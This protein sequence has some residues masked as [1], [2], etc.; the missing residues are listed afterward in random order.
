MRHLLRRGLLLAAGLFCLRQLQAAEPLLLVPTNSVWRFVKGTVEPSP[1]DL[2]AW[3]DNTFG[4]LGWSE[5]AAPFWYGESARFGGTGTEL[6]DMQNAYSTLY[7]RRRFTVSNPDVL[8]SLDLNAVCDDGFMAWINGHPVASRGAP[9][10]PPLF[11]S[12]ASESATEP[13]ASANY[14]IADFTNA[15]VTGDNVLAVQV[16]NVS[17][18]SSDLVFDAELTAMPRLAGP[19]TIASVDPPPG[20]VQS[21]DHITVTFT[22]PVQ[23][24][25]AEDFLVNGASASGVVGNGATYT[26]TFALPPYGEVQASWSTFNEI[27]D[28]ENPPRHFELAA[29]GSTW[30][31]EFVDPS[32]PNLA[33]IQ[34]PPGVAIPRL[35]QVELSFD[36]AVTGLDATDLTLNGVAATRLTGFGAGPYL[37]EFPEAVAGSADLEWVPGHGIASDAFEPHPFSGGGWQYTVEPGLQFPA[38][39]ITEFMAENLTAYRDEDQDP[40]DWIEIRNPTDAAV[41]LEGWSLSNAE[42][43]PGRWVFPAVSIPAR[44]R[45]V[46]FASAKDRRDPAAGARLHTNFKLNPTGGYLGLFSPSLPRQVLSEIRYDDQGANYSYG[47]E[48]DTGEWRFFQGGTPGAPNGTSPI[49]GAVADVRFS[50]KRGFFN[51]PFTLTLSCPTPGA[52]IRYTTNGSPP[53]ESEGFLYTDGIRISASRVLRAAAFAP[54]ARPSGVET[55]TYLLNLPASRLR[56]PALSLVTATN[57]LYGRTGIMEVSP[58]NTNKHGPAWERPVSAEYIRPEDNGGF[59]VDCGIRI[60]GGDYIRGLY[61]YKNNAIPYSKYSYRL[62]FRGEYGQGR[63]EFPLFPGTTQRTF[64]TIVLRAGMNDATNPFMID[65]YV[66]SLAR[67]CGQPSPVGGFVHLFLNGVYKGYYNPC[68]RID[69]DFLRAYH[70]GG[71]AWDVMAQAGEVREGDATAWNTLRTLVNTRNLSIATNYLD[72]AGRLDLTNFVDYLCPLIYVDDDDWPHNNWRAAQERAPGALYRMYVW[73]AEWAFG[74]QNGH[75]PAWNTI[76]NQLSSTAPPWGGV[77]IQRLFGGLKKSAEFRLLF[78]DRVHRHFFNNGALT[79][80]RLKARYADVTNRL[81]GVVTGFNDRVGKTW[82]PQRRKYVLQHFDRAGFLASSNAPVLGQFGGRVT[83]GY[84]LT[85][86]NL[87]GAI[88]YT[89]NGGDPRVPFSGEV[90]DAAVLYR[91]PL[92]L[93]APMHI[94]ARSLDATHW[95][96]LTEADFEVNQVG[97]PLRITEIM[98][99]PPAGDAFEF[100]EIANL[101][102]LPLDVSGFS[103]QGITFRFPEPSPLMPPGARWVLANDARPADFQ[104]RYP[105]VEVA[106][107]YQGSLSNGGERLDILDAQGRVLTS[108]EYSDTPPWPVAAD[109]GGSSLEWVDP[110]GSPGDPAVWIAAPGPGGSPG[111]VPPVLPGPVVRLSEVAAGSGDGGDWIELF[112]PG[113]ASVE[114]T[115]WTLSDSGDPARFVFPAGTTLAAGGW[116]RLWCADVPPSPSGG[117]ATGFRLDR[118]GET[119]ALYDPSAARVDAVTFGSIPGGYSVGRIGGSLAWR[120]CEPTPAAPNEP[121]MIAPDYDVAINEWMSNPP[122]GDDDWIEFHNVNPVA[123]VALHGM[124]VATSNAVVRIG[125]LAFVPPAGFLLLHADGRTGRDHL[126]LKLPASGGMIV[127]RDATGRDLNRVTYPASAEGL[128]FGRIPD[129]IGAPLPFPGT[130]SPGA[131]NYLASAT[132]PLFNEWM[133]RNTGGVADPDSGFADW[134]ELYNP[135]AAAFDLSGAALFVARDDAVPWTFPAGATLPAGGYLVLWSRADHPATTNAAPPYWVDRGLAAEGGSLR[136]VSALGQVLDAADYGPQLADRSVGFISVGVRALLATPT[137]GLA[138]SAAAPLASNASVRLNEWLRGSAD[139]ADWI[140]LFNP[141][142]LP[143]DLGGYHLTDD[144]SIAGATRTTLP[145]LSFLE[146]GGHRRWFADGHPER[147]PDHLEFQL[148]LEG[149]SLR[150]YTA[151]RALVDGVDPGPGRSEVAQGRF[152]DGAEDVVDFPDSQS[153]DRPNWLPHPG[154]VFNEVLAHTDPPLEDAVELFNP[155]AHPVALSGWWLSDDA[156][157]LARVRLGPAFEL[158]PQGYHVLYENV[159]NPAGNTNA[160]TLNS[161]HGGELWLTETDAAGQPTGYRAHAEFDATANGISLGRTRTSLGWELAPMSRRTFG[162]DQPPSIDAFRQGT[163]LPNAY[164]L[165]GPMVVNEIHYHPQKPGAPDPVEAPEDEFVELLNTGSQPAAL[166][167]PAA[168]TNTWRIRGGIE[169]DFPGGV[170]LPSRGFALVVAFAPTNTPVA[171]TFRARFNLASTVPLFGPFSGRLSDEQDDVRL[172]RPD[173]PQAP[174]HPDAGSV[175]HVLVEH[176]HYRASSP[177]PQW[178]TESA[179]SL[180]RRHTLEFGNDPANWILAAPSPGV[181]TQPP[182]FDRDFDGIPNDWEMAHGLNPDDPADAAGDGD[183]DGLTNLAEYLAGTDPTDATS[184]LRLTVGREASVGPVVRFQARAGVRYSLLRRDHPLWGTWERVL[185]VP[186]SD[187]VVEIALPLD[188]QEPGPRYYV[189]VTSQGVGR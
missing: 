2:A 25:R 187:A 161:A 138:N 155:S 57:N 83:A 20:P 3:R 124:F 177:W 167:D 17:L 97:S 188:T 104:A 175:P 70:G 112:N 110:D 93:T 133:A 1:P 79:D 91:L 182:V 159:F 18:G 113:D 41:S 149:E 179:A 132:A 55:H 6:G 45:L 61:S 35:S 96:A 147:G 87:T 145:P 19:P 42:D 116:L 21:L 181:D 68:E 7:L 64:D 122:P 127:L 69:V 178:T 105:G 186:A 63:L 111:S 141:A 72:I 28:F 4:D 49:R 184:V 78:A 170:T 89:T 92:S 166:F 160:F 86:T 117:L 24:V 136:L 150:L 164:P 39:A 80:E 172:E 129:G 99:N 33:S 137:P 56:L 168:P 101:G 71:E 154:V 37:F 130:A 75:T 165:V 67:D 176:V 95:S 103:F 82:I 88:Y 84:R 152:P 100:L 128:A 44:G 5:G 189:V 81:N 126:D 153:P 94:R 30:A 23:G 142:N 98:Y 131:S 180:Q 40:E 13:V 15:L 120:L 9:A 58:R 107:W 121:A 22:E 54:D 139:D 146:A 47:R 38:L 90:A 134:I 53:T 174:P 52:A 123:P 31:Y 51:G 76:Q 163:G 50:V 106:G 125:E 59:Q 118:N 115:G 65:E 102:T 36:K 16:F 27:G 148:D 135:A 60:Q 62:Y 156:D 12:T 73:D 26:F 169:F 143:V 14:P 32:G 119:L 74:T 8:E 158:A 157:R 140:E 173:T 108:V 34:P 11:N 185:D 43:D 114:L 183:R 77:E 46:V 85:I 29:P 48:T 162:I 144:P 66:R 171:D 10:D 151:T 109:G